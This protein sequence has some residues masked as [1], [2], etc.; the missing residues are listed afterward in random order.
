MNDEDCRPRHSTTLAN[1]SVIAR[2]EWIYNSKTSAFYAVFAL[3]GIV[4]FFFT[5]WAVILISVSSCASWYYFGLS[6]RYR[7]ICE[8]FKC[9]NEEVFGGI[10]VE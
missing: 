8:T 7:G 3:L 5:Q 2:R 9:V 1:A 4:A 6:Q 10:E